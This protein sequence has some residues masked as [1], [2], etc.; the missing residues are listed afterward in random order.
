METEADI[1]PSIFDVLILNTLQSFCY[2][3]EFLNVDLSTATLF[4]VICSIS[5]KIIALVDVWQLSS[6]QSLSSNQPS[7][8]SICAARHDGKN[9]AVFLA[10]KMEE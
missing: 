4:W 10:V 7:Y 6:L 9:G 8:E 3:R 2:E 5:R 1:N